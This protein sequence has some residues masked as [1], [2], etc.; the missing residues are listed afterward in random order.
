V[1]AVIPPVIFFE[2]IFRSNN[3]NLA[4][5][6]FLLMLLDLIFLTLAAGNTLLDRLENR[7]VRGAA[8]EGPRLHVNA[9]TQMTG[10]R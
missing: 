2:V 5:V 4:E 6:F 9:R 10:Q 1:C 3:E 7:R 8:P